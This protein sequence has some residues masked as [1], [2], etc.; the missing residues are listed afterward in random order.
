MKPLTLAAIAFGAWYLLRSQSAS[1]APK[2]P[3]GPLPT[4][5]KPRAHASQYTR[6]PPAG[7]IATERGT[8]L[9][10][11][12][13]SVYWYANGDAYVIPDNPS[14]AVYRVPGGSKDL[15]HGR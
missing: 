15:P 4:P 6:E 2:P 5:Q 14:L 10:G 3:Q 12:N 7:Y 9:H 8:G 1:A 11:E 13:A